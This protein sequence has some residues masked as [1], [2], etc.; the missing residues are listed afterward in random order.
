MC[1]LVEVSGIYLIGDSVTAFSQGSFVERILEFWA[2]LGTLASSVQTL[3]D[4]VCFVIVF[5]EFY[6]TCI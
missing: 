3:H 6:V 1:D 2:L 5:H 4:V